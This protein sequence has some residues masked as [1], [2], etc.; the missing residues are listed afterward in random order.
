MYEAVIF[1]MDGVIIDSE[2]VYYNW[3]K[4]LLMEKG[5]MIPEKELKKI[6]G[7]SNAQSLQMMMEWFGREKGRSLWETYPQKYHI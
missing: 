7:L 2:I 1:D 5:C 3:L 4:E 6:V